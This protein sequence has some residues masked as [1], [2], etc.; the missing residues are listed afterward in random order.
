MELDGSMVSMMH[1]A[2]SYLGPS[3]SSREGKVEEE[4]ERDRAKHESV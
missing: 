1:V 3:S 2:A 4:E